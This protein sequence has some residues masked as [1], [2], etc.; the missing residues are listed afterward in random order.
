MPFSKD[1][2]ALSICCGLTSNAMFLINSFFKPKKVK[3]R[4]YYLGSLI[5][6]ILLKEKMCITYCVCY[7]RNYDK[8]R[9]SLRVKIVS[10][11]GRFFSSLTHL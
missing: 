6:I 8:Q 5:H 4:K 7:R 10:T 11:S 3:T 2:V 9:F 1:A